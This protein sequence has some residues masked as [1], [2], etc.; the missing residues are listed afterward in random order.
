MT[1]H[2]YYITATFFKF[3][4]SS[5]A[6]QL[7][8]TTLV[9]DVIFTKLI[10]HHVVRSKVHTLGTYLIEWVHSYVYIG[11]VAEADLLKIYSCP[12]PGGNTRCKKKK[13]SLD[14]PAISEGRSAHPAWFFLG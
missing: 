8:E 3:D 9:G 12:L 2:I 13:L 5:T 7:S 6:Q 10:S 4:R 1:K 11:L 14:S